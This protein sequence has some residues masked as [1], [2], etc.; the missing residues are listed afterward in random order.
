MVEEK[1]KRKNGGV[2]SRLGHRFTEEIEKIKDSKL[3]N[4]TSRDRVSTEK[5]SNLIV[6]H[7]LWRGISEHIIEADEEEVEKFGLEE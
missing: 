1:N 5:I 4:G 7:K 6:R 3:R 2:Q